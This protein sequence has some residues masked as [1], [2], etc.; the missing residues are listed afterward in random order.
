MLLEFVGPEPSEEREV[1]RAG[2]DVHR[3]ELHHTEPLDRAE[4]VRLGRSRFRTSPKPW[5]ITAI[6][7]ASA[8]LK[9][10]TLTARPSL[11]TTRFRRRRRRER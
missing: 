5:A 2:D 9:S 3:V 10:A 6:R 7:R 4:D 8:A 11:R 1:V